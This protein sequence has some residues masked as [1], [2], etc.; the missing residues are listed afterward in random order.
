MKSV[1]KSFRL[2]LSVDNFLLNKAN[3]LGVSQAKII[4]GAIIK[5][6]KADDQW[7]KDLT[8]MSNDLDYKNEQINLA[9]ENYED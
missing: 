1:L 5:V 4:E 7:K 2:S 9:E 6:M 3:E 8:L